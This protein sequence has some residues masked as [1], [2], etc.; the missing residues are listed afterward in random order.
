MHDILKAFIPHE[1]I[2]Y[3]S[4]LPYDV[5]MEQLKTVIGDPELMPLI[6]GINKLYNG[7]VS[8]NV[9][10]AKRATK[11]R[12]IEPVFSGIIIEEN[13]KVKI[14]ATMGIDQWY[15]FVLLI[16]AVA[17]FTIAGNSIA[18]PIFIV[19]FFYGQMLVSF[20]LKAPATKRF[21]EFL[22]QLEKE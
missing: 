1:K 8:A 17:I 5:F 2:V 19:L 3:V 7:T 14:Y 13:N 22:L 16:P 4:Q 15:I 9:F 6:T 11:F 12:S 10:S 18:I 20:K 21:F